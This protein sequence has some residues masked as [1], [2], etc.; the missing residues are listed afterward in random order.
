MSH[1]VVS[2]LC[3]VACS[4]AVSWLHTV[5]V[6]NRDHITTAYCNWDVTEL[7]D[8]TVW[9]HIMYL[10][11]TIVTMFPRLFLP[12]SVNIT[13]KVAPRKYQSFNCRSN[14][15]NLV[16]RRQEF[17]TLFLIHHCK[18]LIHIKTHYLTLKILNNRLKAITNVIYYLDV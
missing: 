5:M 10:R 11:D 7:C 14:M 17:G 1:V 3:A 2:W 4:F 6:W 9:C 8:V 13:V 16:R 15:F 18:T 12:C